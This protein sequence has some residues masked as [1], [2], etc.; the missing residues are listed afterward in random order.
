M[1]AM[2]ED[3]ILSM[4]RVLGAGLLFS[5]SE[6]LKFELAVLLALATIIVLLSEI[7]KQLPRGRSQS[8]R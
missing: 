3:S 6:F 1:V 7:G 4:E 8:N 5:I 2:F